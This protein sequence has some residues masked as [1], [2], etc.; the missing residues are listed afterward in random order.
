MS[1][2]TVNGHFDAG[3]TPSRRCRQQQLTDFSTAA[4]VPFGLSASRTA[5]ARRRRIGI[6]RRSCSTGASRSRPGGSG[7]TAILS[8]GLVLG[9]LTSGRDFDAALAAPLHRPALRVDAPAS[10]PLAQPRPLASPRSELLLTKDLK[11]A[12]QIVRPFAQGFAAAA[13]PRKGGLAA[14]SDP[15]LVG[16]STRRARRSRRSFKSVATA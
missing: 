8:R 1:L 5:R 3:C 15:R 9:M 14:V 7:G 11:N 2:T 13:D 12:V 4:L 6:C 10:R 16:E